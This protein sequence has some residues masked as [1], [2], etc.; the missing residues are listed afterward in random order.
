MRTEPTSVWLPVIP[1][2]PPA[3]CLVKQTL[4][5]HL[6]Y[7]SSHEDIHFPSDMKYATLLLEAK[8]AKFL[9][10]LFPVHTLLHNFPI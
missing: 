9:N 10:K 5:I 4:H 2:G 3:Q 6:T 8:G 1:Q 7:E